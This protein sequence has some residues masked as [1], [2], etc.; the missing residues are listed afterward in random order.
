MPEFSTNEDGSNII[1]N[2]ITLFKYYPLEVQLVWL[3]ELLVCIA[4]K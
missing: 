2:L 1:K 4:Y 3:A